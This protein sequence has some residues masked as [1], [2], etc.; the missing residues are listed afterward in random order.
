MCLVDSRKMLFFV[1][2]PIFLLKEEAWSMHSADTQ[3]RA[4][5]REGQRK[6]FMFKFFLSCHKIYKFYVMDVYWKLDY[7]KSNYTWE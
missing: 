5:G 4:E 2:E 7:C 6:V 3:C 1:T